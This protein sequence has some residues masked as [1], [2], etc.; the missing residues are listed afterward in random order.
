MEQFLGVL[1]A[2][3]TKFA[4]P[5]LPGG[6]VLFKEFHQPSSAQEAVGLRHN[7]LR[8]AYLGGGTILN[9]LDYEKMV[10]EEFRAECLVS[11]E[12]LPVRQIELTSEELV[13]GAMVT[14]QEM[15]E[16]EQVFPVL[17]E[18][19][20]QMRNRNIRNMATV[21]GNIALRSSNGN[22]SVG[23]LAMD[24]NIEIMLPQCEASSAGEVLENSGQ[25]QP[26]KI[27]VCRKVL[28]LA[29]YLEGVETVPGLKEALILKVHIPRAIGEM[30]FATRCYR[31]T[32]NDL[33]ILSADVLVKGTA[34]HIE[35]IRLAMGGIARH[36]ARLTDIENMLLEQGLPKDRDELV[37]AIRPLLHTVSD[38]RGSAEF[39]REVGAQIAA[40]SV[41]KALGQI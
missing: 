37:S 38:V 35:D 5:V 24:A 14:H 11:L 13:I 6:F 9:A 23:L 28:S 29:Q 16:S 7:L 22:I 30:R 15:L 32:A 12:S 21:G 17:K 41:Y 8:A 25:A 40:W 18:I 4:L 20:G 36:A 33:S 26:G 2:R 27:N 1:E 10:P 19:V 39:K 3:V 31:R 34:G